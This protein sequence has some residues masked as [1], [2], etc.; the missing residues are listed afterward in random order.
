MNIKNTLDLDICYLENRKE[1]VKINEAFIT[2]QSR[3]P[4]GIMWTP[5]PPIKQ[6]FI[7]IFMKLHKSTLWV[8]LLPSLKLGK[9]NIFG[10]LFRDLIKKSAK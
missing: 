9:K 5:L 1:R 2:Y 6:T 3:D 10:D 4:G 8:A 7:Y